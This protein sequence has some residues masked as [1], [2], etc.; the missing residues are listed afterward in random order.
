[1][2]IHGRCLSS[3]SSNLSGQLFKLHQVASSGICWQNMQVQL[4]NHK[5]PE[6]C[7]L[8]N[9]RDGRN[10]EGSLGFSMLHAQFGWPNTR[11]RKS[12]YRNADREP[13]QPQSDKDVVSKAT[14]HVRSFVLKRNFLPWAWPRAQGLRDRSAWQFLKPLEQ[15]AM[16]CPS[17]CR[18]LRWAQGFT[19][20]VNM[21][22]QQV[23][24]N[25]R[26]EENQHNL[27]M[28]HGYAVVYMIW[29]A[30]FR[31]NYSCWTQVTFDTSDLWHPACNTCEV[32]LWSSVSETRE[33]AGKSWD[34]QQQSA[35]W[36][37][38][39]EKRDLQ[40]VFN[41]DAMHWTKMILIL[42]TV[43]GLSPSSVRNCIFWQHTVPRCAPLPWCKKDDLPVWRAGCNTSYRR[44]TRWS[45]S[46]TWSKKQK[47]TLY[48]FVYKKS[49]GLFNPMIA[50]K[51]STEC[52]STNWWLHRPQKTTTSKT[53][54]DALQRPS[55]WSFSLPKQEWFDAV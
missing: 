20:A 41:S 54:R 24:N 19:G 1:M 6:H 26:A 35:Q 55:I 46:A 29:H 14:K 32:Q 38:S 2:S 31:H 23:G 53:C 39:R 34:A 37:G 47:K 18:W 10:L 49:V 51:G 13:T 16:C 50:R 12:W 45:A 8:S 30:V 42:P 33:E 28:L 36:S 15:I 4:R 11:S 48:K 9:S 22:F 21:V 40:S 7:H 5:A 25:I 3:N 27:E 52:N 17:E 43:R 44:S